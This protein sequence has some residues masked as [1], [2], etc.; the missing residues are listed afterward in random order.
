VLAVIALLPALASIG[1][2]R[3]LW[4]NAAKP[5]ELTPAL[6]LTILSASVHG[7]LLAIV[8]ATPLGRIL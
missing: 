7:L 6:K 8:L 4:A 2:A 5:A 1:A 3:Q